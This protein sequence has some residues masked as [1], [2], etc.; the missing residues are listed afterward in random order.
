MWASINY[1]MQEFKR[2]EIIQRQRAG[3][4]D[5]KQIAQILNKQGFRNRKGEELTG[6]DVRKEFQKLTEEEESVKKRRENKRAREKAKQ[7]RRLETRHWVETEERRKLIAKL[8]KDQISLEEIAFIL[9]RAGYRS[10]TG[11]EITTEEIKIEHADWQIEEHKK[12][13]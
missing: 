7:A 10:P 9:H 4:L 3:G 8:Y 5:W 11:E 13:I 6:E 12:T 1:G 2:R